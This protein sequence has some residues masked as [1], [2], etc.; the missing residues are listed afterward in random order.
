LNGDVKDWLETIFTNKSHVYDYYDAAHSKL[1]KHHLNLVKKLV[2]KIIESIKFGLFNVRASLINKLIDLGNKQ[3]KEYSNLQSL[4]K[5]NGSNMSECQKI[6]YYLDEVTA[7]TE[8]KIKT[9][10]EYYNS[11]K[12]NFIIMKGKLALD[13]LNWEDKRKAMISE[14][15][16]LNI[17]S[18]SE[19]ERQISIETDEYENKNVLITLN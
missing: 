15:I 18:E 3:K 5:Q 10:L 19:R 16:N 8:N 12:I 7:K 11:L 4:F 9:M 13:I 6:I 14:E 17:S 1:I 2:N